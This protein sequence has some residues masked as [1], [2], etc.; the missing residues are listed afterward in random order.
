MKTFIITICSILLFSN[1]LLSNPKFGVS[2]QV[3]DKNSKDALMFCT[4]SVYSLTD[5]LVTGGITNEKRL[6]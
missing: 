4:V 3:K 6:L 1:T 5:S 2:G